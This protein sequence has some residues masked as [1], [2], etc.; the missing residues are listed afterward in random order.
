MKH[1][2]REE[3][4]RYDEFL[5]EVPKLSRQRRLARWAELLDRYPQRQLSTLEGTEY[6]SGEALGSLRADNSPISVAFADRQLRDDGLT[7]DTYGTA[8]Q[9]FCLTDRQLHNVV[10]SC[11]FGA[12]TFARTS[13]WQVRLAMGHRQTN[14]VLGRLWR[15]LI[16]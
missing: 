14:G 1:L 10:C 12:T 15:T 9:Y 16:G 8:R 7:S 2:P 6:L 13:A 5:F 11:H 4:E 3:F